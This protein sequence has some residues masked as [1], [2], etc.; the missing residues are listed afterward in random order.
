MKF[1]SIDTSSNV[2][3]KSC[4]NLIFRAKSALNLGNDAKLGTTKIQIL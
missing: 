4:L 1:P 2:V 3:L